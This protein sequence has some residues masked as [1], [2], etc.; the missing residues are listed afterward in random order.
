MHQASSV[1]FFSS[2]SLPLVSVLI[3]PESSLQHVFNTETGA[4]YT[5][6]VRIATVNK[7]YNYP[8]PALGDA[9]LQF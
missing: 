4:A 7:V 1:S 8:V 9:Y 3:L 6:K 2:A 5:M